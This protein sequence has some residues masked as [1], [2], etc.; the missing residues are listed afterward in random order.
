MY[1]L[2]VK[3]IVLTIEIFKASVNEVKSSERITSTVLSLLKRFS[4]ANSRIRIV[5]P[6][7]LINKKIFPEL[8]WCVCSVYLIS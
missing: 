6:L 7:R 5:A 3:S 1:L 4:E 2:R 8:V